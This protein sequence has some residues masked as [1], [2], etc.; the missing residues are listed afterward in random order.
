[1]FQQFL[2]GLQITSTTLESGK[3]LGKELFLTAMQ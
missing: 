1:M 2:V 3:I